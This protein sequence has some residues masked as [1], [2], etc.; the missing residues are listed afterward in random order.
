MRWSAAALGRATSWRMQSTGE[1]E[2]EAGNVL[3]LDLRLGGAHRQMTRRGPS[4]A[5]GPGRAL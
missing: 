3:R 1:R 2:K 5:C 4:G